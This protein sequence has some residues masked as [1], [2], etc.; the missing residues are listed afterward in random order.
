[1]IS[2]ILVAT[3]GSETARKSIGYAVDLAKQTGAKITFLSVIDKSFFVSKSIPAAATPIHLIEPIEDYLRQA[4]EAHLEE[5][6]QLCKKKGVQ[7]SMVIRTGHP[8]EEIIKEAEKSKVDLIVMG[9]HGT[10]ALKAAV[11]GSITFGVIHKDTK[12]PVLVVRK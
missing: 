12:F 7:S 11:L 5:V 4:A 3:D 1:M 8:V 10:S 2:K 6:E 9:S